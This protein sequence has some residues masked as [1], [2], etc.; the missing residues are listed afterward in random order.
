MKR[1]NGRFAALGALVA[2]LLLA[3]LPGSAFAGTAEEI[4]SPPALDSLNRTESR[5]FNIGNWSALHWDNGASGHNTGQAT[6]SRWRVAGHYIVVL[7]NSTENPG[8]IA[9]EQLAS[10]N[11][12]LGSIYRYALKGYAAELSKTAV[13]SLRTDPRVKYI[14]PEVRVKAAAQSIPTGIARTFASTNPALDIDGTDDARI[15]VDVAII[16]T[17]VD[18]THPDLNVVARTDCTSGVCVN[19]S[20]TDLFGHGTHVAG[21]VGAID[22]GVGVVGMAPGA[23]LHAVKVLDANGEG[24]SSW[25]IAGIDW[26]TAHASEI[27]VANMSLAG[28]GHEP[29]V[30]EAIA[31]SVDKG[32]VHVVAAGNST[33]NAKGEWPANSPD[34][35]TVSALADYDGQPGGHGG[36]SCYY[37]AADDELAWFSNWGSEVE[38]AAPG[39]C[40]LST[41]P[42]GGYSENYS[43]TS[44]ASPHVAGAAALLASKANPNSRADVESIRSA[45]VNDG[46]LDWSDTSEDGKTEPVLYLGADPLPDTEVKTAGISSTDGQ[47][48]ILAGAIN[49]REL[50]TTYQFEF[51]VTSTYGQVAPPAPQP[52]SS[53]NAYSKVSQTV[54]GLKPD[55]EYHYRLVAKNSQGTFY[56]EDRLFTMSRWVKDLPATKPQTNGSH[57]LQDVTCLAQ[58]CMTVG[59][60]YNSDNFMTSYV[61]SNDVWNYKQVPT[62]IGGSFPELVG[63]SCT[64]TS[65]CTGVGSVQLEDGSVI[66]LAERW[67]GSSWSPQTVPAPPT[68]ASVPYAILN[69]ISC[70]SSTECVAVGYFKGKKAADMWLNYSARWKEGQWSTLVT[71][72]PENTEEATLSDVSCTSATSCVAVGTTY[73]NSTGASPV[74]MTWNGTSWSFQS[75]ARSGGSLAG[76]D[77][78]SSSFCMAVSGGPAA[79]EWNG[80]KW[81][82][83]PPASALYGY[84]ASVSCDS[85]TYCVATGGYRRLRYYG[86]EQVWNGSTWTKHVMADESEAMHGMWGV[87]C[88]GLFGC[89]AIGEAGEDG[90]AALIERRQHV[91]TSQASNVFPMEATL[92]GVII[93][94]NRA[95]TYYFEYGKTSGYGSKA[96]K[97]GEGTIASSSEPVE[98]S[99]AV[100]GLEPETT[101]HYRVVATNTSGTVYGK[102]KTVRT[103]TEPYSLLTSF[104][105]AGGGNGQ[106]GT[107]L[108]SAVDSSGNVWVADCSNNRVQKFAPNGEYLLKFGSTGTGNGQFACPADVAVTSGGDLWVT[109][110]G[111]SRVQK[112]NSKG[113][114]LAKFGSYGLG[115]GFLVEP[116]AIGIGPDGHIWVSDH[117][118]YRVEEFTATGQF[119]RSIH[120]SGWGEAPGEF[121]TPNGIAI[122]PEGNV[123]VCDGGENHRVQKFSPSGGFLTQFG[124]SG[125]GDGEFADP[126]AIEIKP[127]GNMLVAD[128]L[129]GRV[130]EFSPSGQYVG[131]FGS[132]V[133]SGPNDIAFAGAGV[134]YVSNTDKNRIDKWVQSAK[135][136]ATTKGSEEITD[137]SAKLTGAVAPG[138]LATGYHFEYGTSTAYGLVAPAPDQSIAAG[139]NT[140]S[141]S[142]PM[143]NLQP[144]TLYHYRLVA[145]NSHGTSYGADLTFTTART[146]RTAF[147]A[148]D[149]FL[150]TYSAA[151]AGGN[152]ALGMKGGTSPS[153]TTLIDGTFRAAFQDNQGNLWIYSLTGAVGTGLGMLAGTSPSIAPR[154]AGGYIAA[155]QANSGVL[156]Y[157]SSATG[158]KSTNFAM[159]SGTSPAIA[160]LSDGTARIAYQGTNNELRVYSSATGQSTATGLGMLAGTSPAIGPAAGG[161][162]IAAFQ[163]NSGVL[164][165]YSSA[166]G[167]KNTNFA[168]KSG[169][170]PAIAVLSD[171]T[172]R[173]AYQGTNNELR[174]YSSATGQ[175]TAS[176]LG[177]LAGTSPS[178]IALS[179]DVYEVAFQAANTELKTYSSKGSFSGTGLGMMSGT[180]PGIG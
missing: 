144:K 73:N 108:G 41:V 105:S 167:S 178:I 92:T 124:S 81:T 103:T 36:A 138:N 141:V 150:W 44:M 120:G 152:T 95:T 52:F 155:F 161:G 30:D 174:V 59:Y 10:R 151:G 157:Y 127:S 110:S 143:S 9:R 97:T 162:Y 11:G 1:R 126:I 142:Q 35:I 7:N 14:T 140:V 179:A 46:S 119:V 19:N 6:T 27:E 57:W 159:K 128:R 37:W 8:E 166:T 47:S 129:T 15:N 175:S 61:L 74:I 33:S 148:N 79:E 132:G 39:V 86:L 62:P 93:P 75:P 112:F 135:P 85:P 53:S 64:S 72:S 23:R 83:R 173:I 125:V 51:G 58:W 113:E 70:V 115:D 116:G 55:Q 102:D 45:L 89:A 134:I 18:Y 31:K 146:P 104:G 32:V 68:T 26:V 94:G 22:N 137:G 130:Q 121:N 20:G 78:T 88:D 77:C 34:V 63:V 106:F 98:V 43:G 76:I 109:D 158:S 147:Q 101:Y 154:P 56:G 160:V 2:L 122:D 84:L 67:N 180:G 60:H 176:G 177:M 54:T 169:T 90:L 139:S 49:A 168:M 5:L 87:S 28:Y 171:G 153:A 118:Y 172:A 25:V 164:W 12:D 133:I 66:P 156:W 165:Y 145:V 38:I 21:T 96:P 40:I 107:P 16:D 99:Q 100:T 136:L 114:F 3:A 71:P 149:G 24:Y 13:A 17:G 111:N 163:A 65:A 69:D 50:E 48:A 170:S 82:D 131:Q 42:G 123:W 91:T 117:S 80:T 4:S 29:A